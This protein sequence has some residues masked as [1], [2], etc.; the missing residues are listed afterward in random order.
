M[1]TNKSI[2]AVLI[3]AVA[4]SGTVLPSTALAVDVDLAGYFRT[5]TRPDFQGGD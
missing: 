1:K 2:A 4:L 5:S 3:A